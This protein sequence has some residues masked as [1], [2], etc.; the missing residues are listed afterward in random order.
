M[1]DETD[2]CEATNPE[3]GVQCILAKDYKHTVHEWEPDDPN[4]GTLDPADEF[5]K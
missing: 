2:R 4:G 1:L 5:K 3:T